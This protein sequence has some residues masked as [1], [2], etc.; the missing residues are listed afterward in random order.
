M[1]VDPRLNRSNNLCNNQWLL[2]QG[3][4]EPTPAVIS[5]DSFS[6]G[7]SYWRVP[8]PQAHIDEPPKPWHRV[9]AGR[10]AQWSPASLIHISIIGLLLASFCSPLCHAKINCDMLF[11]VQAAELNKLLLAPSTPDYVAAYGLSA[12]GFLKPLKSPK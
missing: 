2:I 6:E 3:F 10:R 12:P 7:V 4:M 5:N 11:C 9:C 1:A 8:Q